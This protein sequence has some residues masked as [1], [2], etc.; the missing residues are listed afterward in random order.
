MRTRYRM[1]R[2]AGHGY[3]VAVTMAVPFPLFAFVAVLIGL[4]M[5]GCAPETYGY[6]LYYPSYDSSGV[7]PV[8]INGILVMVPISGYR[9]PSH[10]DTI[11]PA[12]GHF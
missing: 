2:K 12:L 6:K 3:F 11:P 4:L 10:R 1:Y 7:A 9:L 5:A 8:Y